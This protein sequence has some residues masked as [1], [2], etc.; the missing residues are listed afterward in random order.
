MTCAAGGVRNAETLLAHLR[1]AE[2]EGRHAQ[3]RGDVTE[4]R[5][6]TEEPRGGSRLSS[7]ASE[8]AP[9]T[10]KPTEGLGLG[11]LGLGGI[12]SAMLSCCHRP[13]TGYGRGQGVGPCSPKGDQ[14]C[15]S[16]CCAEVQRGGG[17][18][19]GGKACESTPC[20]TAKPSTFPT[21]APTKV[22][23]PR[24]SAAPTPQPMPRPSAAPT[25]VPTTPSA[26]PSYAPSCSEDVSER[27][28]M[29]W[30]PIPPMGQMGAATLPDWVGMGPNPALMKRL[31]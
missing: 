2:L 9:K 17:R 20:P 23:T 13:V 19:G 21:P 7:S 11:G 3:S 18:G 15:I 25:H 29:A 16:T 24:P 4:G 8:S 31:E 27:F 26:S 10:A 30:A 12:N 5:T 6:Q 1:K 28:K 14:R 22:P